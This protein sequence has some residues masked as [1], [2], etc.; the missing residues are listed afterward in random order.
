MDNAIRETTKTIR[1]ANSRKNHSSSKKESN[2]FATTLSE[3]P[4]APPNSPELLPYQVKYEISYYGD[5]VSD[6][7]RMTDILATAF[8]HEATKDGYLG[9]LPETPELT[10][11]IRYDTEVP[12]HYLMESPTT[13]MPLKQLPIG[14]AK[15]LVRHSN[16][17]FGQ[18]T[19]GTLLNIHRKTYF[20]GCR[21]RIDNITYRFSPE[22]SGSDLEYIN[23]YTNTMGV[24]IPYQ[25]AFK[26]ATNSNF[27][28]GTPPPN[29]PTESKSIPITQLLLN[30]NAQ[31]RAKKNQGLDSERYQK[32]HALGERSKAF[33]QRANP[34][35]QSMT[36][37]NYIRTKIVNFI[38]NGFYAANPGAG[39]NYSRVNHAYLNNTVTGLVSEIQTIIDIMEKITGMDLGILHG[40]LEKL[41]ASQSENYQEF[42]L[43][44]RPYY[45]QLFNLLEG[46][47]KILGIFV[48]QAP[49]QDA[50]KVTKE[51]L[52]WMNALDNTVQMVLGRISDNTLSSG[53]RTNISLFKTKQ[54]H[55]FNSHAQPLYEKYEQMIKNGLLSYLEKVVEEVQRI[56]AVFVQ[57]D[58]DSTK[59]L[60]NV[61]EDA[62]ETDKP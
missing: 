38:K 28:T 60:I 1:A 14:G 42:L 56:E 32:L 3:S 24:S 15:T 16:T 13:N 30:Q 19:S 9:E 35:L 37:E 47:S 7:D 39:S 22:S 59:I 31:E 54:S 58:K 43:A 4:E 40:I 48:P 11:Y 17:Y 18:K 61:S 55:L 51:E 20:S 10:N 50:D 8:E 45:H 29:N 21:I 57:Q 41:K 44:L 62:L 25:E 27:S 49:P 52:R 2:P 53:I 6:I 46:A 34:Y 26:D 5:K 23:S 36:P 12:G 33:R